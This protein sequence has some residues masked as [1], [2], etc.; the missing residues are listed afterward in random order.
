MRRVVPVYSNR[1]PQ[2][3][4]VAAAAAAAAKD[5]ASISVLVHT[6]APRRRSTYIQAAALIRMLCIS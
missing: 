6:S 2:I 5:V 4:A 3:N 1:Q